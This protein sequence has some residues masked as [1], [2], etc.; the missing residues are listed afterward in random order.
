[1]PT[2]TDSIGITRNNNHVV[3]TQKKKIVKTLGIAHFSNVYKRT[4]LKW[5]VRQPAVVADSPIETALTEADALVPFL[6]IGA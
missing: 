1:M 4:L 2:I 6:V 5:I 3:S